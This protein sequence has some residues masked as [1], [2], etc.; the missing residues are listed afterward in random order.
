MAVKPAA[1]PLRRVTQQTFDECVQENID[2]FDLEPE[3]AVADAVKEFTLQ[4]VDLSEIDKSYAG[5][6]GRGEHPVVALT[7][8]FVEAVESKTSLSDSPTRETVTS[9]AE[10]LRNAMTSADAVPGW[11]MACV[12]AGAVQASSLFVTK[13]ALCFEDSKTDTELLNTALDTLAAVLTAQEAKE[14]YASLKFPMAFVNE[15]WQACQKS[16][17]KTKSLFAK[18]VA[19]ASLKCE[20]CKGAFVKAEIETCLVEILSECTDRSNEGTMGK[21]SDDNTDIAA[22]KRNALREACSA[23]RALTT[24]DDPREPASGAF[25]HARALAKAGAATALCA[26]FQLESN[27]NETDLAVLQQIAAA[28]RHVAV[29]DEICRETSE[30]GGL[31]CALN[32]LKGN[33][34]SSAKTTKA[35]AQLVRQLAGSDIVKPLIVQHGGIAALNHC[36]RVFGERAEISNANETRDENT[37]E[38]KN[39]HDDAQSCLSAV[40]QCVGALAATCLKHPEAPTQCSSDS[41]FETVADVMASKSAIPHKGVQRQC[42]MFFRNA[43]VRNQELRGQM[44]ATTVEQSLRLAKKN[45]PSFCMDVA[46]AALRDLGCPNYNEGYNPTTAVMGADGVVRTP[47]ELGDEPDVDAVRAIAGYGS[48]M[49]SLQE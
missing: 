26:A 45:H 12:G 29:N 20:A 25:A 7:K 47:E 27:E 24:G 1:K 5:P 35:C 38:T 16:N 42:C 21:H 23:T 14:T 43:V 8:A 28:I 18:V 10:A 40:E 30:K 49:P 31:L 4:G 32:L 3:E 34:T 6:E 9:A 15:T 13:C 17:F 37:S 22:T 11:G 46:T 39:A 36:A 19:N 48:S 2:D 41:V 44:L 33:A